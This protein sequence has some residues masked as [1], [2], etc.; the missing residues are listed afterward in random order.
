VVRVT[1]DKEKDDY[2]TSLWMVSSQGSE[3]QQLTNGPRD[4]GP[5]WSPDGSQLVFF[6]SSEK[7]GKPEPPQLYLLRFSGGEPR[8]LTSLPR[9]AASCAWS[10]DGK[11]L[12]FLSTTSPKDLAKAAENAAASGK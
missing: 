5:V 11:T 10:P 7:E 2:E 3:V 4:M 12:A 8:A 1:V 9:G 6:R